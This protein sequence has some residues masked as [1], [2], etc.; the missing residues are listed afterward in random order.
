M[1]STIRNAVDSAQ[2]A[3]Q[4]TYTRLDSE[5]N[6]QDKVSTASRRVEESLRDADQEWGVRR[7]FRSSREYLKRNVPMWKNKARDFLS[8]PQGKVAAVVA[9]FMLVQLPIFWQIV[10][11]LLLLWWASIPISLLMVGMAQQNEQKKMQAQQ[12]ARA[13]K[14]ANP[15]SDI[16]TQAR[17]STRPGRGQQGGGRKG[18]SDGPIIDADYTV[19]DPK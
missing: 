18:Q 14:A 16:F 13:R 11:T 19:I 12:A 5:Y 10:N 17:S 6:I 7:K 9:V 2:S 3:A 1:E 8:T 15:F 4:R